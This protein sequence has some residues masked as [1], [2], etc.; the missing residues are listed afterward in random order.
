MKDIE[1]ITISELF[2]LFKKIFKEKNL[3][4]PQFDGKKFWQPLKAIL[5]QSK[6]Q[7]KSWKKKNKNYIIEIMNLPEY[8]INGYNIKELDKTN[9]FVI[10]TVRIPLSKKE[11]Q[12]DEEELPNLKKILQVALNIGQYLAFTKKTSMKY[13]KITDYITEKESNVKVIDILHYND[14]KQLLYLLT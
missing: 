1:K 11:A 13:N 3:N 14:I 4:D 10:Q 5:G 9:H 12:K 8:Y 7:A 6:W 2:N